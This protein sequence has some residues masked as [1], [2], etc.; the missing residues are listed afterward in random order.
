M[1]DS[2]T[3]RTTLNSPPPSVNAP[4]KAYIGISMATVLWAMNTNAVKLTV[5]EIPP[6]L[7]TSM[8]L[9]LAATTLSI[10]HF[11]KGGSFRLQRGER[12]DMG[13]LGLVGIAFSFFC[14]T[15]GLSYTSVSHAVF[16]NSLVP[17]AVLII[18]RLHGLETI[19]PPKLIGLLLSLAGVLFLVLDKTGGRNAGWIGDIL[20]VGASL[21]FAW[22]TVEGKKV[23]TNRSSLEFNTFAFISAA[24]WMSPVLATGLV[25]MNWSGVTWV[26]WATLLFSATFGSAGAYMAYYSSLQLLPP[27]RTAAFHYLQPPL[28][29]FLSVLI[30]HDRITIRFGAG[31]ALILAGL[32]IARSRWKNPRPE[33]G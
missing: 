11:L 9:T 20:V 1:P 3:S 31:A 17:L 26:A 16:I 23:A 22:L 15:T 33:L 4:W 29:T 28:A 6:V 5:R 7:T 13:K 25:R 10:A 27:S 12:W 18:S 8:R 24:L 19:T 2:L 14:L 30:F 21:S 32:V